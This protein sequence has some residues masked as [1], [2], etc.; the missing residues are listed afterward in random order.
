MDKTMEN[1]IWLSS[2]SIKEENTLKHPLLLHYFPKEDE[3]DRQLIC[4]VSHQR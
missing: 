1:N 2:I 3:S 4:I